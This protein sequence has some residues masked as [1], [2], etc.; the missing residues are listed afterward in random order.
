MKQHLK[1]FS[2]LALQLFSSGLSAVEETASQEI[3]LFYWDARP[4]LGFSNFGDA[5]SEAIIER[6]LG[7]T[8]P[9]T[10]DPNCSRQ[11]LLGIGSIMNYAQDNDLVW[12]TGVNGT[13][14]Q[15]SYRFTQLDV[16]AVRGPLS[17][18][19]LLKRGIDCP[20][21]YGD[22]TLLFPL[23]FPEFQKPAEP[24]YEFIIIP[25]FSD[26]PLFAGYPNMVSVKEH[27]SIV[28]QKILASKFVISSALSGIIIAEAFG[29]PARLLQIDNKSNTEDLFKYTDYYLGTNRSM[30]RFATSVE[31]ALKMG[32]EPLPQ[33]DLEALKNSFPFDKV[34]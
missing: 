28:V 20:E 2:L 24:Q 10:N 18:E 33:C 1:V 27:W 8:I 22:P 6:I 12:G 15:Q 5:L 32:G 17:R 3:P 21:I 23:L 9:T 16:R 34:K 30:F 19:F 31:E 11:K 14:P 7:H 4:K 25:H 29:I 26:E 13:A